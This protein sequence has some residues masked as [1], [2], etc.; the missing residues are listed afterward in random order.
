M[1]GFSSSSATREQGHATGLYSGIGVYPCSASLGFRGSPTPRPQE[2]ATSQPTSSMKDLFCSF[3]DCVS[4]FNHRLLLNLR[5]PKLVEAPYRLHLVHRRRFRYQVHPPP[6]PFEN[7]GGRAPAVSAPPPDSHTVGLQVP[8]AAQSRS[9]FD[10]TPSPFPRFTP[11]PVCFPS[12]FPSLSVS[13]TGVR[14]S[15]AHCLV[16]STHSAVPAQSTWDNPPSSVYGFSEPSHPPAQ[17]FYPD[18]PGEEFYAESESLDTASANKSDEL[19]KVVVKKLLLRKYLD[20]IYNPVPRSL[21]G[22]IPP[23]FRKRDSF[24]HLLLLMRGLPS[25]QTS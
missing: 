3:M 5:L 4:A 18:D 20:Q 24:N 17:D 22:L 1:T 7:L 23:P 10:P 8:L 6:P 2:V 12:A 15:A 25:R 9:G 14:V 11:P 13:G 21:L 19:G 16:S